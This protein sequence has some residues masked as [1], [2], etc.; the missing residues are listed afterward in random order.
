M[1]LPGRSKEK[2]NILRDIRTLNPE[3]ASIIVGAKIIKKQ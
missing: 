3:T 1:V 2:A